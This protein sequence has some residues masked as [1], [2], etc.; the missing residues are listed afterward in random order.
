MPAQEI[1]SEIERSLDFLA[2]RLRN[3]PE[4]HRSLRAVFH[5]AWHS[6]TDHE[7]N[8][9]SRLSIFRGSFSREVAEQI[10]EASLPMLSALVDKS[11]VW[12]RPDDRYEIHELLRQYA[13]E[14]LAEQPAQQAATQRMHAEYF[15]A[16]LGRLEPDLKYARQL[17]A[18]AHISTDKE[19]LRIAWQ[20]AVETA[21][22]S[23]IDQALEPWFRYCEYG[24]YPRE[25][26]HMLHQMAV[27]MAELPAESID[28]T[29]EAQRLLLARAQWRQG[30]FS[31][32]VGQ[33]LDQAV[34]LM[35]HSA[36]Q[37]RQVKGDVR[38]ELAAVLCHV[39][40]LI[41]SQGDA[42]HAEQVL[43]ESLALAEEIG[44]QGQIG[45]TWLN[46]GQIADFAGKY[47]DADLFFANSVHSFDRV[48][49]QSRRS[50]AFNNWGRAQ[51][52]MGHYARAWHLVTEALAI[53]RQFND[54]VG[55]AF[56]LL[57]LGRI[58]ECR[59]EYQAAEQ[60]IKESLTMAEGIA[61]RELMARGLEGLASV[62]LLVGDEQL[63]EGY[64]NQAIDI[65]RQQ[66][67]RV[68]RCLVGLGR[69]ASHRQ[70]Y[71]AARR[72]LMESIQLAR[73]TA[74]PGE[75]V[76]AEL[77]LGTLALAVQQMAEA[78]H[79]LQHC[80]EITAETGAMPV[81]LDAMVAIA[82][83]ALA[84]DP[85]S[86]A[87]AASLLLMVAHHP[88]AWEYTRQSAQ[89]LLNSLQ[90][91][92]S[93]IVPLHISD[94]WTPDGAWQASDQLLRQWL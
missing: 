83:L 18:L 21:H 75:E 78:A 4:R 38:T 92:L 14:K 29:P 33:P 56:S 11:L 58:A 64:F 31:Y 40:G 41:F 94:H 46:L 87:R 10:A 27:R 69:L 24:G 89:Q 32:R 55:I 53:R 30:W 28:L 16:F 48:G 3:L 74:N 80:L 42:G 54:V 77:A 70:D 35:K 68:A 9:F 26:L 59:G 8:V 84:G 34:G 36:E 63:A 7:R 2:T 66:K 6:L 17:A 13:A 19:N 12:R 20:W 51:Y 50:Y 88:A 52:G 67:H 57:D 61:Y 73:E 43:Q 15:A 62:A 76:R 5:H 90:L 93:S 25:G 47:R 45:Q 86:T 81:T 91:D 44:D 37:L 1:C 22:Y 72:Y 82:R 23:L 71:G 49:E 65:H 60:Y 79:H 85:G 39:G